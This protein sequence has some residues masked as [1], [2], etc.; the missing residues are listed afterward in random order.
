MC[1]SRCRHLLL[2]R[3]RT[4]R[5][6]AAETQPRRLR[7]PAGWPVCLGQILGVSWLSSTSAVTLES[8][9]RNDRRNETK[10]GNLELLGFCGRL[11]T[12]SPGGG[13]RPRH[14]MASGP[15]AVR[16]LGAV[17]RGRLPHH[18]SVTVIVPSIPASRCPSISQKISKVPALVGIRYRSSCFPE[19]TSASLRSGPL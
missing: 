10:N 13:E 17:P 3:R 19:K 5:P 18:Y 16:I 6:P 11:N 15:F 12:S 4:H 2:P 14:Q 1:L 7:H 9:Y 8:D